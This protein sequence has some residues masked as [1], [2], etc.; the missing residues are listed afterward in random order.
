MQATERFSTA[1]SPLQHQLVRRLPFR[2]VEEGS[3]MATQ[4]GISRRERRA[5]ASL[6]RSTSQYTGTAGDTLNA[7]VGVFLAYPS[8]KGAAFIDRA[9]YMPKGWANDPKRRAEAGVPEK[10]IFENKVELAKEMLKRAFEAGIPKQA[11]QRA[12]WWRIRSTAARKPSGLGWRNGDDPTRSW[13]S[14]PTPSRSAGA[15]R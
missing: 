6:A 5:S 2:L 7:Q 8:E 1:C 12:G 15:G 4:D 3:R 9:L 10:I 13:S 11:S 14:R